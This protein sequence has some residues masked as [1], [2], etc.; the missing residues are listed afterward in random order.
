MAKMKKG[1]YG[2]T[3]TKSPNI[4]GEVVIGSG[5]FTNKKGEILSE[6]YEPIH[7]FTVQV[8]SEFRGRVYVLNLMPSQCKHIEKNNV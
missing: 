4:L 7:Y 5:H 2:M 6:R 1:K 3:F 8:S